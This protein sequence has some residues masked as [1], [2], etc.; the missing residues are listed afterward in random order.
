[1]GLSSKCSQ[2]KSFYKYYFGR[3]SFEQAELVPV[4]ILVGALGASLAILLDCIIF[5]ISIPRC[6]K[7]IYVNSLFP[8]AATLSNS[9]PVE[10]FLLNHDLNGFKLKINGNVLSL[11]SFYIAFLYNF[12]L[13]LLAFLVTLCFLVVV[14]WS[15][16]QSKKF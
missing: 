6:F 9:L 1:M 15:E 16:S 2:L 5:F 4:L 8:G 10:C 7:D 11:G 14:A 3:Y 12:Y 13:F